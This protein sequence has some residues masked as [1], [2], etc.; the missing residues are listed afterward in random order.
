MIEVYSDV[1]QFRGS[2]YDFGYMQGNL[3]KDSPILA[4]RKKQWQSMRKTQFTTNEFEY[5]RLMNNIAPNLLEEL[6]GLADALQISLHESIREF[7]GYY[8]EDGRS[9]CTIFVGNEFMIRN[10]DNDP[11]SYEGRFVLFKPTT[12]GY[13]TIGPSMQITGRTDGMNEKGLAIG[14][15]FINTK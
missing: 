14:Y 2:H 7:G 3:L 4:N 12:E 9:G 1:V 15:N 10:Y 11:L 5:I 13:A 6:Q 8:K